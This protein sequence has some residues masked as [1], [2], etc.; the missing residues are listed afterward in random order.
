MSKWKQTDQLCPCNNS[1]AY[2]IDVEGNGFCFSG[3]CKSPVFI[4]PDNR[5]NKRGEEIETTLNY[6]GQG[7]AEHVSQRGLSLP[8]IKLYDIKTKFIDQTPVEIA[9]KY[10]WDEIKVRGVEKKTFRTEGKSQ[11]G[12]FGKDKFDPGS[13]ES[14][15]ITEGEFDAPSI[16]EAVRGQTAACSVHSASQAKRDCIADRDYINSFSRIII[17]F[18]ND[19]AGQRAAKE[20]SSLFDFNKV[21]HLKLSKYK[22]ASDYFQNGEVDNLEKAWKAAKRYSPDNII[23]S[24]SDIRKA[25]DESK[26]D[27]LADW[28]FNNLNSKLFGIFKGEVTVIKAQE[29][30]GKTSLFRA[31]EYSILSQTKIPIGILH[32]EEPNSRTIKGLAGYHLGRPAIK[33]DS[34]L[35]DGDVYDA[36]VDL[37]KVDDR[38]FF[39]KSWDVENEENFFSNIRFLV[40]ACGCK[41]ICLDHITWLA[42][43]ADTDDER[44]RLDRYSQKLKLLAEELGFALIEISAVNDDGKTRGSRNISKAADNVIMITR[45]ITSSDED[46]ASSIHFMIEKTRLGEAGY[47]GK[48]KMNKETGRLEEPKYIDEDRMK[49]A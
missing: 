18:D 15:T 20:V 19:E 23:S 41:I 27:R 43:G 1:H 30:V 33:P 22:D 49:V 10:P 6:K 11:P 4:H 14:I 21:Y 25:L 46:D 8:T 2:A 17:C 38:V 3:T 47:A 24:F 35:S 13:K 45:N 16:Y 5:K 36:F 39:Y 44:K 29:G 28:P 12:L 26:D 31:L 40:V 32:L 42:T 34:G 37:V 7:T 48:I 9:F